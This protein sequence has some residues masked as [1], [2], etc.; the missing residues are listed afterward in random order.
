MYLSFL[1]ILDNCYSNPLID[2]SFQNLAIPSC[3]YDPLPGELFHP[4]FC[5]ESYGCCHRTV[6]L[7]L[8]ALLK[9]LPNSF[10]ACT[11][12]DI[13]GDGYCNDESNNL[14]CNY[15]GRDCCGDC[16]NTDYCT[17]CICHNE[18]NFINPYTV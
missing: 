12:L 2:T 8:K 17:E 15:D 3:C 9:F 1:L 6:F 5:K 18:T 14:E 7:S 11:L 10:L 4:L 13:V 16:V